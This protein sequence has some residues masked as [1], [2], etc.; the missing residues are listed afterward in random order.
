MKKY[1]QITIVLGSF[2]IL[3]F[4]R[5]L[6]GTED[7]N[8]PIINQVP[9]QTIPPE[10]FSTPGPTSSPQSSSMMPSVMPQM[11]GAYKTGHMRDRLQM[12]ITDIFKFRLLFKT[13]E[14]QTLLFCNIQAT[15]AHPYL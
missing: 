4:L 8:Q 9:L 12:H 3:V 7:I 5:N 2:F 14:S 10:V 13:A 11:M 15:T 6:K 1:F